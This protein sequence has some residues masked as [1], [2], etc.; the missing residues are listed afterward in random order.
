MTSLTRRLFGGVLLGTTASAFGGWGAGAATG[1]RTHRVAI[2]AF[3]FQPAELTVAVGDRVEWHN[4]DLAPHTATD[5]DGL[6]DT[7]ELG[8]GDSRSVR[9]DRPGRVD[10]FC[11]FHPHMTGKITV[12]SSS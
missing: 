12:A 7:G 11:A 9:F 4:H 2:Q 8:K 6:W 10:Y 1:S 5:I 3:A